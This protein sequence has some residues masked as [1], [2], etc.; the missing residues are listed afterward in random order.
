[1][2]VNSQNPIYLDYNATTPVHAEV[3]EAMWPWFSEDFGNA[4]SRSHAWGWRADQAVKSAREEVRALIGAIQ[5]ELV[6]TSGATE[7]LNLGIKG[8][9]SSWRDKKKH[10][11]CW[12][13]EHKAVLDVC[14]SLRREGFETTVLSVLPSGLPDLMAYKAAL[15]PDTLL[16]CG[17]LANNETGVVFPVQELTEA[18]H[19][20]S[21]FFMCDATQAVGK[22]EVDVEALGVD[23]LAFSAHKF[24]GPKGIGALWIRKK[25]G[26]KLQPLLH[27]GA[28]EAGLRSGTLAV[29]LIVGMGKAAVLVQRHRP[30]KQQALQQLRD[31]LEHALQAAL[32][33]IRFLGAEA[34]RLPNTSNV[35]LADCPAASLI[36]ALRNLAVATGSACSSASA[37]P[38]HVLLAMGLSEV[39]AACCLRLSLGWPSHAQDVETAVALLTKAVEKLRA[40]APAWQYRH[41]T[42][43]F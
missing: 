30:A 1:M 27:G 4:A 8:L 33:E 41:K 36:K 13:T 11:I 35:F 3:L 19:L 29:P 37:S 25:P 16:V 39:D 10:L 40:N 21:S 38:S 2:K 12:A 43:A 24:Y 34:S 18:A 20:N 23:L 42:N 28:H 26:L 22:I 17:M 9:A 32:P 31:A 7:A 14:K 5:G 6:F 15:R